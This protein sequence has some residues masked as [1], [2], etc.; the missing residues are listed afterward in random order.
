MRYIRL[1]ITSGRGLLKVCGSLLGPA[2]VAAIF[3]CVAGATDTLVFAAA[4]LREALDE[5]ARQ[6][7]FASGNKAVVSYGASSI[8]AKQIENGAPASL[9][10]SADREWMDYLVV[11]RLV[12]VRSR[13]DLLSN[14]LAL[15]AP[16]GSDVQVRITR[17]FPLAALLG[18]ER[19]AMADPDHVPAGKYAKA[20]LETLDVWTGV[21]DKIARAMD[22]RAALVLVARGEAPIGI[23]YRTDA[24]ADRRV[25]VVGEFPVTSHAPIIY[26]AALTASD[27][28]PAG[29]EFLDFLRARSSRAVWEKYGFGVLP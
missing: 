19:L 3:P 12:D 2:L 25:R 8:L 28:G 26:P 13:V 1:Y 11:R 29:S 9:F 17:G 21:A 27:R 10:I 23:V 4:S 7:A 6:F 18:R 24:L 15:I 14:R 16:A 20:A 22:V 5:Q